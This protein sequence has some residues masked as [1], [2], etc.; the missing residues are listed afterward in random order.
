MLARIH[1]DHRHI[2][3]LLDVLEGKAERLEQGEGVRLPLI[4]DIVDYLQTYADHSPVSYT[5]LT[6]P[7]IA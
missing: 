3:I 4:R 6:L 2:L 1:T 5:H 7:T